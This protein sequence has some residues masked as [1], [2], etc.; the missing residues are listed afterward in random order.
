MDKDKIT[1]EI[2]EWINANKEILPLNVDYW[3]INVYENNAIEI[4][5]REMSFGKYNSIDLSTNKFY[6][7]ISR[8]VKLK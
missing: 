8:I 6:K 2:R 3:D 4:T 7:P 1:S 5:V